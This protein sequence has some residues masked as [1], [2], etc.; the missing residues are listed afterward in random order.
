MNYIENVS[1]TSFEEGLLGCIKGLKFDPQIG[2][3]GP[4]TFI[5]EDNKLLPKH[6]TVQF[7]FDPQHEET[8]GWDEDSQFLAERFPYRTGTRRG[9]PQMPTTTNEDVRRTNEIKTLEQYGED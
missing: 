4:G 7:G 6:F 8:L 1:D 2:T 3:G 9:E 5:D